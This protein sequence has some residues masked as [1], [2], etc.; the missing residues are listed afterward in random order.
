MVV[1]D[2]GDQVSCKDVPGESQTLVNDNE[3]V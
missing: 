3:R 1:T 2:T